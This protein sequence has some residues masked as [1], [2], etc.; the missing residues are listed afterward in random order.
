MLKFLWVLPFLLCLSKNLSSENFY[1]I[2]SASIQTPTEKMRSL[3]GLVAYCESQTQTDLARVRFYFVWIATHIKYDEKLTDDK[4]TPLTVFNT[5]KA[6][7]SGYSRLLMQLCEQSGIVVRYVAGYGKD[8]HDAT[9][10]Q[11]H[12][13]NVIYVDGEWHAF[14]VTWAANDLDD[15]KQVPLS[16]AFE[17]WFMPQMAAFQK[18]H[19]AFD[20]AYQLTNQLVTRDIF[21]NKQSEK[22]II[23]EGGDSLHFNFKKILGDESRLDSIGRT[24]L[25]FRR[26]Y[27]FMPY[28]SAV[29]IK[30]AKIQAAKVKPVFDSVQAFN[31]NYYPKITQLAVEKRRDWALKLQGLEIPLM[32]SL[33]LYAELETL[34]LS[35]DNKKNVKQNLLYYKKL[36]DFAKKVASELNNEIALRE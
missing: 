27:D 2:D 21:F 1:S 9:N 32:E 34:P 26:A 36:V 8:I 11:N 4:Q 30:L 24:W 35:D 12:A 33:K 19:L 29:A 6:V 10:I 16:P 13:W 5:K 15:N 20:P 25:S 3:D 7:C 14:D 28:D 31:K 18:T 23:T 22:A 17:K